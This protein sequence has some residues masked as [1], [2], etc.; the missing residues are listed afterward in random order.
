L[1]LAIV[2]TIMRQADGSVTLL[3]PAQGRSDGFEIVLKFPAA[4]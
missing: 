4:L 2:D 1:G 3:S